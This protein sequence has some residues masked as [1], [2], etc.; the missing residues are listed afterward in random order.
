MCSILPGKGVDPGTGA[1]AQPGGLQPFVERVGQPERLVALDQLG[2]S[3]LVCES[4]CLY[5]LGGMEPATVME[6]V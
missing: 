2:L 4:M 5:C 3:V 1:W 6:Q